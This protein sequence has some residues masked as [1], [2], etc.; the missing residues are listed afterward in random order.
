MDTPLTSI[1]ITHNK[2][3]P[4]RRM[5]KTTQI[6][7]STLTK[8]RRHI[9]V[10]TQVSFRRRN[11]LVNIRPIIRLLQ[12]SSLSRVATLICNISRNS[13]R[14]PTI[15]SKSSPL[16]KVSRFKTIT[17][18]LSTTPTRQSQTTNT[19]I[20][21]ITSRIIRIPTITNNLTH[22]TTQNQTNISPRRSSRKRN[23]STIHPRATII[24]TKNII[25]KPN[26][27]T[28][29]RRKSTKSSSL[30]SCCTYFGIN[31]DR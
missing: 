1:L 6:M 4:R 27:I 21:P 5:I 29:K 11:R 22:I 26:I 8:N 14:G 9:H 15:R 19:S 31:G 2:S 3:N 28:P 25:R 13:N 12:N 30:C 16:T 7:T 17:E 20:S 24:S 10:I 23:S 18:K